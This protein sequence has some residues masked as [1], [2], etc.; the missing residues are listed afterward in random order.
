MKT[1][2]ILILMAGCGIEKSNDSVAETLKYKLEMIVT[3]Y[4]IGGGSIIFPKEGC[5]FELSGTKYTEYRECDALDEE[6]ELQHLSGEPVSF[7]VVSNG[8]VYMG[9]LAKPP[10]V[11]NSMV[12]DDDRASR[13]ETAT[14]PSGSKIEMNFLY[15]KE[16]P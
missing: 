1:I 7:E 4:S 10:F 2:L 5:Y 3:T 14:L 16:N 15:I 13:L 8:D 12:I 9:V 11:S 6:G